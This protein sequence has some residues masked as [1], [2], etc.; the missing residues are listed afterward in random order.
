MRSTLQG[1]EGAQSGAQRV[2]IVGVNLHSGQVRAFNKTQITI[3]E[4]AEFLEIIKG[5]ADAS[6]SGDD[7]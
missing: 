7:G 4:P 6:G 5:R 2:L 3:T 1:N